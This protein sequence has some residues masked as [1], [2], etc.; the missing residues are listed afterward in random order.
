[1]RAAP[2]AIRRRGRPLRHADPYAM[3]TFDLGVRPE[4]DLDRALSRASAMDDEETVRKLER[5]K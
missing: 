5:A 1:M 4:I 3:P 2:A